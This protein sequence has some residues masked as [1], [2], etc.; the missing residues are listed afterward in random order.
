M[1]CLECSAVTR[2]IRSVQIN[3]KQ[4]ASVERKKM[5]LALS[6]LAV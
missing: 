3:V 4:A 2:G 5:P 1:L 6:G